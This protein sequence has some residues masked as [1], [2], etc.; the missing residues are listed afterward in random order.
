MKPTKKLLGG[1]LMG[2]LLCVLTVALVSWSGDRD[3]KTGQSQNDTIPRKHAEP[4]NLDE[5]LEQIESM[6]IEEQLQEAR[7]QVEKAMKEVD[8]EK[9]RTQ[10]ESAMKDLDFDKI[11]KQI[12]ESVAK[13]DLDK[14][15]EEMSKIDFEELE[16]ELKESLEKIDMDKLKEEI[17]RVKEVDMK[18]L[19]TQMAKL[20]EEMKEMGPRLEKEMSKAKEEME[21]ARVEIREYK[22]FVDGLEKDGLIDKKKGFT[23]EHRDGELFINEKKASAATYEKYGEFLKKHSPFRM[24]E[25]D[26]QFELDND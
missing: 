9:I 12:R 11:E 5:V 2:A 6:D 21:K 26:K 24:V 13:I 3:R 18:E 10:M 15:K 16:A 8:F 23:L 19:E 1:L 22:E 14:M 20:K 7:Q 4:R 25:N 17:R